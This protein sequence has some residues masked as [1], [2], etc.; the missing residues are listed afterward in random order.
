LLFPGQT[1]LDPIAMALGRVLWTPRDDFG[2]VGCRWFFGLVG[3]RGCVPEK[4]D[5]EPP[6]RTQRLFDFDGRSALLVT[7]RGT[8]PLELC[9]P[10]LSEAGCTSRPIELEGIGFPRNVERAALDRDLLAIEIVRPESSILVLCDLDLDTATCANR[11]PIEGVRDARAPAVSGRRVVWTEFHEGERS[12]IYT[13]EVNGDGECNRHRLAGTHAPADAPRIDGHRVVWQDA[14]LGPIQI[15]GVELPRIRLR[16]RLIVS[17]GRGVHQV[18][19]AEDG[20]GESL[21]LSIEPV[22]GPTPE[23]WHARIKDLGR[24]RALLEFQPPV[25]TAEQTV[26]WRLHGTAASGLETSHEI[27]ID[28]VGTQKS[29]RWKRPQ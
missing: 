24:G 11:R 28:V 14:R 5:L 1:R 12:S 27:Q 29:R 9:S 26:Q 25:A 16:P 8:R 21:T 10:V 7:S 4:I 23:A 19:R 20:L 17:P 13:C 6:V 15:F 22:T 3:T 2:V 18:F